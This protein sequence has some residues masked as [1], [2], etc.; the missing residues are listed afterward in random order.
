MNIEDLII[1]NKKKIADIYLCIADKPKPYSEDLVDL[2][3]LF[4][5]YELLFFE[6]ENTT[7]FKNKKAIFNDLL[8]IK[9]ILND[10]LIELTDF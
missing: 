9:D 2:L 5:G 6:I 4:R 1:I 7:K 10:S 3:I 8:E